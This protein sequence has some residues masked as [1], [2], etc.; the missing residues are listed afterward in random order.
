MDK[1]KEYNYLFVLST[2]PRLHARS[3]FLEL[4]VLLSSEARQRTIFTKKYWRQ[5]LGVHYHVL[6]WI[7]SFRGHS[8][9]SGESRIFQ[10]GVTIA[11][12]G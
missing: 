2:M 6:E 11:K 8:V 1:T 9:T 4:G 3:R 5:V 10:R 7:R 12:W